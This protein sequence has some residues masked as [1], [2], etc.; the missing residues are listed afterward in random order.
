MVKSG[1]GKIRKSQKEISCGCY[2]TPSKDKAKLVIYAALNTTPNIEA[3]RVVASIMKKRK[4]EGDAD[5]TV[6]NFCL[7][8][9]G[10]R[11]EEA[12]IAVVKQAMTNKPI[13][14][15]ENVATAKAALP[16]KYV[17]KYKISMLNIVA[18]ISLTVQEL[19]NIYRLER[20]VDANIMDIYS[21]VLMCIRDIKKLIQYYEDHHACTC[22]ESRG[23]ECKF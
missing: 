2:D 4:S 11:R 9:S 16:D 3:H 10:D 17:S 6:N 19:E 18:M 8:Q 21:K 23:K 12:Q 14:L 5:P 13:L 22:K 7:K 20:M 15:A 1:R